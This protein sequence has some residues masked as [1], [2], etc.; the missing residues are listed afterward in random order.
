MKISIFEAFVVSVG[1]KGSTKY[2]GVRLWISGSLGNT[3]IF[4][5]FSIVIE[6]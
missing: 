3:I 4:L 6:A 2:R 5:A 1:I